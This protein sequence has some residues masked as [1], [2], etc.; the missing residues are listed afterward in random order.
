[1]SDSPGER[2]ASLNIV[3]GQVRAFFAFDIGYEVSLERVSQLLD[4]NPKQPLSR[5]KQTP[6]YL[7][8]T[9]VPH[10]LPLGE[11]QVCHHWTAEMEATIFDFGA[12]SMAYRWVLP[13]E[14]EALKL[15]DLPTMSEQLYHCDLEAHARD[16][17]QTLMGRIYPAIIRPELSALV[18]D[19][20]IFIL[21]EFDAPVSAQDLLTIHHSTLAQVLQFDTRQLSEGQRKEALSHTIS[22]YDND[23][24][25]I[26]WNASVIYDA[27][28]DDTLNV[29]ELLNVELLSTHSLRLPD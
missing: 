16:Q 19:Y 21:E 27:D 5:K 11:A 12:V 14:G 20:Y 17:L 26:D 1:M 24:V 22:Y 15:S 13:T 10:V 9:Q 8:Y 4:S 18:E 7:Q 2:L 25:L 23:L 28:Y 6:N 3:K 29:L